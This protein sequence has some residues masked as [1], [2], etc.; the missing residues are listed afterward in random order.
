MHRRTGGEESRTAE[1]RNGRRALRELL[2]PQ[3]EGEG[4]ERENSEN[5][6]LLHEFALVASTHIALS[7]LIDPVAY[8]GIACATERS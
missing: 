5:S 6:K 3:R 1:A 2:E 4:N 7:L 8:I